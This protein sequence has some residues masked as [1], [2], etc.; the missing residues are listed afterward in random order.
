M[1]DPELFKDAT[2]PDPTKDYFT[3]LVGEGKKFKDEKALAFSK[4]MSD[5]HIS[6]IES[7]NARLRGELSKQVTL[8]DLLTE[9]QRVTKSPEHSGAP[10]PPLE[11]TQLSPEEL[12]K[13]MSALLEAKLP[14]VA[15]QVEKQNRAK[16]NVQSVVDTLE[17]VWGKDYTQKLESEM[18]RLEL[19]PDFIKTLAAERPK[20][21]LKL[22]GVE[23]KSEGNPPVFSGTVSTSGLGSSVTGEK[24]MSYY[25]K[26][27]KDNKTL[28]DSPAIQLE[29]YNQA[30]KLRE[31]FF[32]I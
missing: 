24:T 31:K 23:E 11:G 4:V 12:D 5:N 6:N 10:P 28:Y 8:Q 30:L 29:K 7:E 17:K 32:D 26:M 16:Q 15:T 1:P 20:A 22:V 13:R 3:E 27:K 14:S 19:G 9:V 18:K 2:L 25:N 21:L